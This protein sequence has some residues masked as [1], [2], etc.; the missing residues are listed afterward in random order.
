MLR[1]HELTMERRLV[2]R[3]L[4]GEMH[5]FQEIVLGVTQ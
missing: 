1:N 5:I 4:S 3:G 2:S